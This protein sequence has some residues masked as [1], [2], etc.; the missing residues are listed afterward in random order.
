M[1]G[2]WRP[3][4]G[5]GVTAASPLQSPRLRTGNSLLFAA[6]GAVALLLFAPFLVEGRV[7]WS[8]DIGRVYYP[9]AGLLREALRTVDVSRLLWC[10]SL[11]AGFPM[12]ADGVTTPFYPPHWPLLLLLH[13]A[14]ALTAALL[15]AYLAS[16]LA[17]ASFVRTLGLGRA[18]AAVAGLVY[19]WCG[20]AVGHAV[21][22][23]MVAGLPFLPLTLI[24]LERA[25]RAAPARHVTMAGLSLGAQCLGGHPQ[26][27]LMS[28]ALGTGYA[29]VRLWP[30]R[31]SARDL[32]R[33]AGLV[34]LFVGIG[35]GISAVYYLP[36][37]ELAR[38]S[39]RPEGGLSHARAVA[40]ALPLPHLVTA[41]SPFFFFDPRTSAYQGAWNP[42]EMAL[43]AGLP[44]LFLAGFALVSRP[45]DPLAR[46][47]GAVALVA[48][49]IAL[50]DAT[51]LHGLLH[52]LP[53]L[54]GLRAPGRYVLLVDASLAVLAALGLDSLQRAAGAR[55]PRRAWLVL[56]VVAGLAVGL[57][58]AASS[59]RG[60]L[61][62]DGWRD[63]DWTSG[64]PALLAAHAWL[65]PLW[66]AST[67]AWLWWRPRSRVSSWW[68]AAGVVLVAADLSTF[69]V[70][71]LSTQWVRPEAVLRPD[72]ALALAASAGAGRTYVVGDPAPWRSASDLPLLLGSRSL[73]AYV[74]LPLA[75]HAL[76]TRAFWM[77]DQTAA[78]LLD[79]AAVASVVDSWRR[80][81][82]PRSTLGGE[83]FSPRHP[84]AGVGPARPERE[85]RFLLG[86]VTADRIRLVTSLHDATEILQD[87]EVAQVT[88]EATDGPPLT[89]RLRAGRE[90][91]E[92]LHDPHVAHLQPAPHVSAWSFFDRRS[93]GSFY[94]ARFDLPGTRR[95]VSLRIAYTAGRGGL[96][97]FGGSVAGPDGGTSL[98][99]FQQD[100]YRRVREEAG[101]VLYENERARPRAFAVHRAM[102][103]GS[104]AEAVRRLAAGEVRPE[105]A[106][107]L[108]DPA[109][110]AVNG[111]GPSLVT[112]GADEPL[113]VDLFATMK[114]DGYVVLADTFYP[115]WRATVD[116]APA[117][118][119][120][121]NGLFRAV[122]VR[123]GAHR[124]R[125]DYRPRALLL[126]AAVTLVTAFLAAGLVLARPP[127]KAT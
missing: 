43:Y 107:V 109:A 118:I 67:A 116:G 115:G 119:L 98:S 26:V 30:R 47:F 6:L 56:A 14:R 44:T 39:V 120:V 84:L 124:V 89:F 112:I 3:R 83:E 91:A 105:D 73:D 100:R 87:A 57:P 125:F 72:A 60:R 81:L 19:A 55:M 69:A 52:S 74:S 45:R 1:A 96:L 123:D 114:G 2:R 122:F 37:A 35:A 71:S 108:E 95:L 97:V 22:V 99:P 127:S 61:A 53:V 40:Y 8:Q 62:G 104:T 58:L 103:A 23:N 110:P 12:V 50:G 75:R 51:P 4:A 29:L 90:T 82:D 25:A 31:L 16:G 64:P 48:L 86:N 59:W 24:F 80:P 13:P 15:G 85:V 54:R 121:A 88:L 77:S 20:F 101:A 41:V 102:V 113:H 117:P 93:E 9:V 21:H 49:L 46:F 36:M 11:G 111:G 66:L 94:L 18:A 17:M 78:G 34:A 42:A 68:P 32:A 10:P 70:T 106:V 79:A 28:A 38:Q 27:V 92:R 126:G 65:A 63:A 76:Y 5:A 33:P 7:L